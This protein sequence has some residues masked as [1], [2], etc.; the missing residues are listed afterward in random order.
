MTGGTAGIARPRAFGP[1][2]V[3]ADPENAG[4]PPPRSSRSRGACR[5]G[6]QGNTAAENAD[7][8][9]ELGQGDL[10]APPGGGIK[11]NWQFP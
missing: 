11:A 10:A 4:W 8:L 1:P 9:G 2:A 6:V 3:P 5:V 7:G